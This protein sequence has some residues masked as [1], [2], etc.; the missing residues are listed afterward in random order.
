MRHARCRTGRGDERL[1]AH[2]AGFEINRRIEKD[3]LVDDREI[4]DQFGGQ[5][6]AG[7]HGDIRWN[8]VLFQP[9]R[10]QRAERVIAPDRTAV[11]DDQDLH[12]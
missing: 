1:T 4:G 2:R 8:A 12:R 10:Y 11:T 3:R 6:V 7:D 5:D 9:I